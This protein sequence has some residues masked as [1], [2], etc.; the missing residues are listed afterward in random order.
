MRSGGQRPTQLP[1]ADQG[2]VLGRRDQ[3][4]KPGDVEV[5]VLVVQVPEQPLLREL[6]QVV[7]VHDVPGPR[8]D[9]PL[10]GQVQL[11]VVSVEVRVVALP[12]RRLVPRIRGGGVVQTVR[13]IEVHA[14]RHSASRHGPFQ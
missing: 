2:D 7:Q 5:Q 6:L 13:G 12:V 11:V 10:D 1:P 3:V 14:P 9:L 8:V 4:P